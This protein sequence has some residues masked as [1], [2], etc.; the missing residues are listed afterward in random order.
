[1]ITTMSLRDNL[2][3]S[4]KE[5]FETM[6]FM[7]LEEIADEQEGPGL[8][9]ETLLG[10]ITFK[11]HLEGCLAICCGCRCARTIAANMLGGDPDEPMSDDD[12]SDAIGEVANMVMGA[13]KARVH[14]EVGT[15][16]VSIPSVVRGRE[17]RNSLGERASKIS[18]T[19]NLEEEHN[20]QFSLL[21]RESQP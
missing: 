20:V 12:M 5:V 18:V 10:T 21:Y 4:A 19:V 3:D 16:E 9:D 13:L 7:A 2:L 6:A 11:G 14:E 17:L 15:M 8:E 1:M